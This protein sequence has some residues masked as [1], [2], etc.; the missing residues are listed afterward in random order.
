MCDGRSVID[1]FRERLTAVDAVLHVVDEGPA[2]SGL[3]RAL[4][5]GASVAGWEEALAYVS[6]GNGLAGAS[7]LLAPA[8]PSAEDI[9]TAEVSLILAQVGVAETGALGIVHSPTR[10]REVALLPDRQIALL[11]ASDLVSSMEIALTRLFGAN[12]TPHSVIFIAGPSRT[13]D[14]EQRMMLGVHAPRSLDVIVF[15]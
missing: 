8:S 11:R 4:T 14:I 9:R 5:G 15:G 2:L 12:E 1:L 6:S 3:V 13:A 7:N 10:P